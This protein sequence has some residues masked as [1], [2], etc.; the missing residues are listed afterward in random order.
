MSTR[1]D[2]LEGADGVL[3]RDKTTLETS[4]DLGDGE[5]LGHE[6]LDLTSTLDL[7]EVGEILPN[8]SCLEV[9]TVSLSSS[10]NSSITRIAMIS[11]SDL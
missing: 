10:E 1:Q 11:W 6:T 7:K 5:G 9:L 4:E 3:E 2:L 8:R